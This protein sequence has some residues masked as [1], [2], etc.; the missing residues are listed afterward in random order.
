MS[1]KGYWALFVVVQ[2]AG[3]VLPVLKLPTRVPLLA[4]LLLLLPGDLLASVAGKINPFVFYPVVFFVNAGVWA[5]VWF[6][7][8][9]MLLPDTVA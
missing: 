2:A 6:V 1:K 3:A 7:V 8:R 4:G 9:K 5:G